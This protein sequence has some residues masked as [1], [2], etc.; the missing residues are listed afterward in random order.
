M[1]PESDI[2]EPI[3]S[4]KLYTPCKCTGCDIDIDI[5]METDTDTDN[6]VAEDVRA[7]NL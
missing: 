4:A 2:F 6:V 7:T 5:D 1:L 3:Y